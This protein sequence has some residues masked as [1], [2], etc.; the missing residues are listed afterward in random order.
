MN[1][2]QEIAKV[3]TDWLDKLITVRNYAKKIDKSV[4]WVYELGRRRDIKIIKIDGVKFV[5]L[6]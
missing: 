5:K 4:Q 2:E 3:L 1:K 6:D